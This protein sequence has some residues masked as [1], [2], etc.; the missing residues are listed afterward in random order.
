MKEETRVTGP[1]LFGKEPVSFLRFKDSLQPSKTYF[2]TS[3]EVREHLKFLQKAVNEGE[4]EETVA[5][6]YYPLFKKYKDIIKIYLKNRKVEENQVKAKLIL[7]HGAPG[8]GKSTLANELIKNATLK[9]ST[10]AERSGLMATQVS[11]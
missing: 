9:S 2:E 5:T 10:T 6:K 1:F 8:T 11:T 3:G 4:T 7:V